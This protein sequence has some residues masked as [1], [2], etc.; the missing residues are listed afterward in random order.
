[1]KGE[2]MKTFRQIAMIKENNYEQH[3]MSEIYLQIKKFEKELGVEYIDDLVFYGFK[4]WKLMNYIEPTRIGKAFSIALTRHLQF[5][6]DTVDIH[7]FDDILRF[8]SEF[9]YVGFDY[10]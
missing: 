1:M 9:L 3:I 5:K 4:V 6:D 2:I 10:E 7:N 8:S